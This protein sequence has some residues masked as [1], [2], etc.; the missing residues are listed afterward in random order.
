MKIRK[1]EGRHK[2]TMMRKE[3]KVLEVNKL[4][5]KINDLEICKKQFNNIFS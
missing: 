4:D 3:V 5:V 2:I 1:K